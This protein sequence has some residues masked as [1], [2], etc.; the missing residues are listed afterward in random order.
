[1]NA[2]RKDF[3]REIRHTFSRFLSILILV[4]LAVAFLS[5][6]R[7]TAPDMKNTCDA[8]LDAQSFMDVQILSTLG[9]TEEDLSIL[10]AQPGVEQAEPAWVID[11]YA[12]E[13]AADVV[14]KLYSLPRDLNRLT[15]KSGRLP[16][17]E[18]ECVVDAVLMRRMGLKLGDTVEF[19]PSGEFEEV[20]TR[21]VF[22]IVGTV[23]SPLYIS[24][25]RGSSTLGTGQV[26]A[27]AYVPESAFDLDFYTSAFLTVEHAEAAP[28]F[29][30]EYDE[31]VDPVMDALE[32]VGKA[33][34]KLR[35]ESL[36]NEGN[37][38]LAEAQQELD[39]AKA[40]AELELSQA[41]QK[42][43][44]ARRELDEGWKAYRDGQAELKEKTADAR[45]ELADGEA[46]LAQ[47]LQD[48]KDGEA[49][50]KKAQQDYQEGQRDYQ[51]G[52]AEYEDGLAAFQAGKA[53]YEDGLATWEK[54]R[55]RLREGWEQ[56]EK[57][58]NQ[59]K[60]GKARIREAYA[61]L[62][63]GEA[64]YQ[65]AYAQFDGSL[66]PM[67][68]PSAKS[69]LDSLN[70]EGSSGPAHAALDAK[71]SALRAP[72][73]AGKAQIHA[74]LTDLQGKEAQLKG[75][76]GAIDAQ[77]AQI[78][79]V[80]AALPPVTPDPVQPLPDR[81]ELEAQ[82]AALLAQKRELK[83]QLSQVQ[84]G[85][86]QAQAK[87]Q[88]L[89]AQEQAAAIPP[90]AGAVQAQLN[91]AYGQ[92]ADARRELDGGWADLHRGEEELSR[93]KPKLD[94]ARRELDDGERQLKAGKA[95]LEEAKAELDQGQQELDQA[96]GELLDA[97]AKLSDAQRQLDQGRQDL[98]Q[99]WTDYREGQQDLADG[100]LELQEQ[101]AQAQADLA[102]AEGKLRKGEAEYA[103]GLRDY[104]EGRQK[105]EEQIAD[106]QDKIGDARRKIAD[107]GDSEWYILGREANP[108]YLGYG[109]DADR[110][111]NLASV[112]PLLF[113][114]VAALVC[115][116]TMTRM[117]EEQ[118][119]Q[120]G[121][122]K[123]LG[124]S[125]W[126]ISKKYLGYGLLPSVLGGLLGLGLGFTL[127][128]KMIY[129]AYQ[130]MYDL[131]DVRLSLYPGIAALSLAAAVACTTVSSLS[132][133]LHELRETPAALMRPKAP[134]AGKRVLLEYIRPLW[135]RMSFNHKV[136][137]R[138][139][140]RY[141]K[142]FWMTVMGIGGCT[143]LIIAGFGLRSSLTTTM[144]VQYDEI[145]H[146][147][148]QVATSENLLPQER[149]AI[150][151]DIRQEK[152][153]VDS[154]P[155]RIATVTAESPRYNTSAYLEVVDPE[156]IED[157]VDL[158]TYGDRAPLSI[159]DKGVILDRKLSELL[160][161]G[162]GDRFTI[163]GER[164]V[165]LTVAAVNEN[166]LGHFIYLSPDYYQEVFG[167]PAAHNAYLMTFTNTDLALCDRIFTRLMTLHG[168][169]AASRMLS[170]R[171][172]YTQA[173]ERVDFVVLIIIL[174]A[175]ALALVVLYNLSNIN[176]TERKRE[177]ATIRV[178]GFYDW[179]VSAYVN[180]ENLVLT[181]LGILFG[182]G[183]GRLLHLWLVRSVEI[184]FMMFGRETD[185]MAYL[186]AALLTLLFSGAVALLSHRKMTKINMVESLKSAE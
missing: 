70:A 94:E 52:K 115:L 150:E 181:V 66:A 166:Y 107:I 21:S 67:G 96:K 76:I 38:K 35:R 34:A 122:L 128:P 5:G 134:K 14:T 102:Q 86:A 171:D 51:K 182:I 82:R 119:V 131:P 124:Y 77:I 53:E 129:V 164:R 104:E 9:L 186:W 118:R 156:R 20:L 135:R 29:S 60:D 22:T 3:I 93:S 11:V 139:L 167:K 125:R 69:L 114:L 106:A 158:R 92:L 55:D 65:S 170:T 111:A 8:Y 163:D 84:G 46:D 12:H 172:T 103:D 26:G 68:V 110:M 45:Q 48:L 72:I 42:L 154:L 120:I 23:R 50:L 174:S 95:K 148:A 10:A 176:I 117:V 80:L 30:P 15:V 160:D 44:H 33:R 185:P 97:Q 165:E 157:F 25:E 2:L 126:A 162:P 4:A 116:T 151:D 145:F 153:I 73:E 88:A 59:Y 132:A 43:S 19:L 56:Y 155:C 41:R 175:A 143:A 121:S 105:A 47:A 112:F 28:A 127:F 161:V 74:A 58:L 27:F 16:A 168:V 130:M 24:P 89:E 137:A 133:C 183:A 141:Q 31:I 79:D 54:S 1:M 123:A 184:D 101:V 49:E 13:E 152:D 113:F 179:E 39:E 142:R 177:L 62:D 178:L 6:L 180:R 85:I 87:L 40:D 108:G 144:D 140:L 83:G 61:Q 90:N 99:G 17:A 32:A 159:P 146:Y 91:G 98:D 57:G 63:Q 71:L 75:A 78:D 81:A 18:D 149:A 100:K 64:Q 109:Q 173:M 7:S 37:E 138:N 136:T 36:V 147:T 169:L